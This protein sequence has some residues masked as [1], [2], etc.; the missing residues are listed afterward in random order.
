MKTFSVCFLNKHGFWITNWGQHFNLDDIGWEI[1][2]KHVETEQCLAYGY[3]CGHN[4]RNLT[5]SRNRIVLWQVENLKEKLEKLKE[6]YEKRNEIDWLNE[7]NETLRGI[8]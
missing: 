6:D 2:E 4:S 3:Y 1:V 5:S 8:K 7:V